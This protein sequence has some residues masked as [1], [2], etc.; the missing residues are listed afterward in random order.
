MYILYFYI[1]Y[2]IYYIIIYYILYIILYI[3][4][5]NYIYKKIKEEKECSNIYKQLIP[6]GEDSKYV[7][8]YPAICKYISGLKFKTFYLGHD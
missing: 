1:I 5:L 8:Q 3:I 6:N 7:K 2:I 4:F